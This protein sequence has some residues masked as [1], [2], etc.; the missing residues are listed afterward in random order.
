MSMRV[1]AKIYPLTIPAGGQ[2][3]LLAVGS[4][5]KVLSASGT[6]EVT[7]DAF[8]Q[9]GALLPGQGLRLQNPDGSAAFFGRLTFRDTSGNANNLTVLVAGDGFVD[10]RITGEVSVI[11]GGKSR[12]LALS[13]FS[14]GKY[15]GASPG[16]YSVVQ[17]RNVSATMRLVVSQ[18]TVQAGTT[19][20]N[21][22]IYYGANALATL[23]GAA[24]NKRLGSA[25]SINGQ[26][27][28]D[29]IAAVPPAGAAAIPLFQIS[30][31][32]QGGFTYRLTEP[33][34]VPPT[35]TI[36]VVG[37]VV[38]N[39]VGASFEFYEELDA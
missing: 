34:I 7:G 16:N 28:A 30:L 25:A 11:D 27:R 31:Q 19:A 3:N 38:N 8:G 15:T 1:P 24:P 4:Y 39:G 29:T 21:L 23:V 6:F 33:L 2:F 9:L 37:A 14:G 32:A 20:D 36:T 35:Q 10:D 22:S 18:I 17:L 12:S 13:C 5:F 26:L